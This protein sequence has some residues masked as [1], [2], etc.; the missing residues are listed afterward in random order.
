VGPHFTGAGGL[1]LF[2]GISGV[3]VSRVKP[4]GGEAW[5]EWICGGDA[6]LSRYRLNNIELSTENTVDG[7]SANRLTTTLCG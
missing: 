5:V 6:L 2:I 3:W 7:S 4:L 1:H